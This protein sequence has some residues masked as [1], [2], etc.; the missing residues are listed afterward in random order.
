MKKFIRKYKESDLQKKLF[1]LSIAC[2]LMSCCL[3]VATT[4][5]ETLPG[6]CYLLSGW[7]SILVDPSQLLIWTANF[8]YFA[9]IIKWCKSYIMLLFPSAALLLGSHMLEHPHITY[10]IEVPILHF[11]IGYYLWMTSFAI[12]CVSYIA[13]LF[14]KKA[15]CLNT[16]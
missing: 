2:Y 11:G 13:G 14:R 8:F 15:G 9:G 16:L 3:P 4:R 6:I 5:N 7:L 1:F 10:D 12:L